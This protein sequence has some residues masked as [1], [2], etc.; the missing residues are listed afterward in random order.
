MPSVGTPLDAATT[1][2]V[3]AWVTSAGSSAPTSDAGSTP[4]TDAATGPATG[5]DAGPPFAPI[6]VA[7]G[8]TTAVTDPQGNVWAAD[9][10]FTGGIAAVTSPAAAITGTDTP[11]LYNGQRYGNPSFSYASTVPNGTYTVTLKYAEQYVTGPAMRLFD[12]AMDGTAVETN[13]DIYATAG[14]MNIAVDEPFT[15]VVSG[16]SIQLAFT[17]GTIQSPKIDAIEI[18]QGASAVGDASTD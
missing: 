14:G 1:Q 3:L 13:F 4:V 12:V 6:R 17:A 2:C 9:T 5:V 16:G 10:G 8:Q 7:A 18:S 15:V 11:A